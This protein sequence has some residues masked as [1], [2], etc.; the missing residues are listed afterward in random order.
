MYSESVLGA[1]AKD[2]PRPVSSPMEEAIQK[3]DSAISD[4][5]LVLSTLHDRLENGGVITKPEG[6]TKLDGPQVYESA[7]FAKLVTSILDRT[8]VIYMHT[9][10]AREL[11]NR[12][13]I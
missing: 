10:S 9:A 12:L 13:V 7:G 8:N 11:I 5:A 2:T 3:L 1:S 4:L 6:K